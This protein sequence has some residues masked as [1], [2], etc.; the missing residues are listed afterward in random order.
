MLIDDYR[1]LSDALSVIVKKEKNSN[2]QQEPPHDCHQFASV[3]R[4]AL[5][6]TGAFVHVRIYLFKTLVVQN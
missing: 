4:A 5:D 3:L 2:E 6:S 1:A